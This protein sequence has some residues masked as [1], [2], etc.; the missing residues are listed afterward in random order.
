MVIVEP[1][2]NGPFYTLPDTLYVLGSKSFSILLSS[3]QDEKENTIAA[4]K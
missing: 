2:T 3:L 1:L 4:D